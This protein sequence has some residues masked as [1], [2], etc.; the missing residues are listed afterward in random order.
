VLGGGVGALTAAYW[1]TEKPGWQDEYQ[2]TVYQMGWRLGGKG[3]S[4][5]NPDPELGRRIEEHGLHI[6]FGC[7][8]NA[9][10]TLAQVLRQ[11]RALP[12][13][14][15]KTFASWRD[16]FEP[17]GLVVF[18]ER[19]TGGRWGQWPVLFPPN[20]S[21]PGAGGLYDAWALIGSLVGW[22]L[23]VHDNVEHRE[24]GTL[25]ELLKRVMPD[26]LVD[27]PGSVLDVLRGARNAITGTYL[28]L[29]GWLM[30]RIRE[31]MELEGPDAGV[32]QMEEQRS[33]MLKLLERH[34]RSLA[35]GVRVSLD[36]P[37]VRRLWELSDLG[38]T[39][40]FGAIV[41]GVPW[42]GWES[43]DDWDLRAWLRHHGASEQAIK[44]S[45]VETFYDLAFA[46]QNGDTDRPNFA[47]GTALYAILRV[48]FTY[49][50]AIMFEMQAGMGDSV[51]T[52]LYGLLKARGV[53]FEFFHKVESLEVDRHRANKVG[54]IRM[55]E[56]ATVKPEVEARG[57]YWPL[58]RVGELD[59]WPSEPDWSQLVEG[60]ELAHDAHE[61]GRPYDLESYWSAW[62][63]VR[64]KKLELGRD[65][66]EVV[67]GLSLGPVPVVC[68]ELLR[69]NARWRRMLEGDRT[70]SGVE[71]TR[72]QGVQLWFRKTTEELGFQPPPWMYEKQREDRTALGLTAV[73]GGY[74]QPLDTWADLTHLLAREQWSGR[75]RPKS[76]AY[77]CGPF[78]ERPAD[79]PFSDH[80]FPRRMRE[81]VE[82]QAL[83]WLRRFG[84]E[85]WPN[86]ESAAYRT[87]VDPKHL[88][89]PRNRTGAHRFRAQFYKVN[90]DPSERYVLTVAGSTKHR[91]DG[92]DTGFANLYLAGDWTRNPV[93][94]VGC[95]EAAVASGMQVA[96]AI[97]RIPI[98]IIGEREQR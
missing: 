21:E 30:G 14:P 69:K 6:W 72:T 86:A 9:F 32:R 43:L 18:G 29:V 13:P 64:R 65:F 1:L 93:V 27:L 35:W 96:R 77:L 45:L 62:R 70:G 50:G 46:Y 90:F 26:S 63:G 59:C 37:E 51:F 58:V 41:D 79:R 31:V 4:G 16:A 20:D 88:F 44:S 95:V 22:L 34:R 12:E 81:A 78:P 52:P 3:S 94:S 97:A 24:E 15:V 82:R 61:P 55:V 92:T 87:G 17:H 56:Q 66:D 7:Y 89:D 60:K 10:R 68:R 42:R 47:A 39:V 76:L 74:E 23:R 48:C 28:H 80:A 85:L 67:Y 8:E 54:A 25:A 75:S 57:G 40:V 83:E 2:I 5:R 49:N 71:T 53:K 33:L 11:L 73:L 38:I 36:D 19:Q 91:L 84:G 98:E